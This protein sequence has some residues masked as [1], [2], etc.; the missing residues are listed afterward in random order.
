[1]GTSGSKEW[2]ATMIRSSYAQSWSL[3]NTAIWLVDSDRSLPLW[4]GRPLWEIWHTPL[5]PPPT[6]QTHTHTRTHVQAIHTSWE[7]PEPRGRIP[8]SPTALVIW[9]HFWSAPLWLLN[10]QLTVILPREGEH[11]DIEKIQ[12][13]LNFNNSLTTMSPFG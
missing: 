6:S 7:F 2:W 4:G 3:K 1:M 5:Q 8:A 12:L 10:S 11:W 9:I 13:N